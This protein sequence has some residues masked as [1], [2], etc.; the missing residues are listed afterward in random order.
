MLRRLIKNREKRGVK[1]VYQ[2][3]K[4]GTL[5]RGYFAYTWSNMVQDKI[6]QKKSLVFEVQGF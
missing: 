5:L 2:I 3:A 1:V 4:N 6:G